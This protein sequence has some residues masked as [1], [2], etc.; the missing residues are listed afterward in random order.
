MRLFVAVDLD[1]GTRNGAAGIIGELSR[2]DFDVKWVDPANLHMTLK[3]LGEVREDQVNFIEGRISSAL[4]GVKEFRISVGGAGYFGR[5]DR[6]R[7]LWI[8]V[9]QG[10][11]ALAGISR[12][13]GRELGGIR[14]EDHEPN[15]HLT[16]GRVK[17]CRNREGLLREL[18]RLEHV[19]IG[20]V[21]VK[22]IKLKQS[23][24]ERDGPRYS[25]LKVFPL[26]RAA[27]TDRVKQDQ[28]LA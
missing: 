11:D 24:L 13:L 7:T 10:R 4:A 6:I 20:E 12:E 3:F 2:K 8:G 25:D 17:S 28:G 22:E 16:I 27:V 18:E 9:N 5:P 23:I 21:S 15:P 19:K 26:G 14:R 1:E